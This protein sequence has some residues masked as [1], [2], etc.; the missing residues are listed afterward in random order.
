LIDW[1]AVDV[2]IFSI[3]VAIVRLSQRDLIRLNRDAMLSIVQCH[4]NPVRVRIK[5]LAICSTRWTRSCCIL[6]CSALLSL[7]AGARLLRNI[8][9]KAS[10]LL[11]AHIRE[12]VTEHVNNRIQEGRLATAILSQYQVASSAETCR[13]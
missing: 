12:F 9:Q 3:C 1:L 4:L 11:L 13:R 6:L 8:I 5:I 7:L 2:V 10:F